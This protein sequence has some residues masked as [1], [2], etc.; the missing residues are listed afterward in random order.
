MSDKSG[1]EEDPGRRGDLIAYKAEDG[2][3]ILVS[4][5]FAN[6]DIVSCS[7][8]LT[9][10]MAGA[11]PREW[12]KEVVANALLATLRSAGYGEGH[13]IHTIRKFSKNQSV[14]CVRFELQASADALIALK[15]VKIAN[16]MCT[17][18]KYGD[19]PIRIQLSRVPLAATV[20]EVVNVVKHLGTVLQITRPLIQG[21]EDHIVSILLMPFQEANFVEEQNKVLRSAIFGGQ[22]HTIQYRCLSE[23][24]VC[25]ACKEKGHFNGQKCPMINRCFSCNQ[26]GHKSYACPSKVRTPHHSRGDVPRQHALPEEQ[27]K[28]TKALTKQPA[29]IIPPLEPTAFS[30]TGGGLP[31]LVPGGGTTWGDFSAI[32]DNERSRS[33]HRSIETTPPEEHESEQVKL[34][35]VKR[36]AELR[37][38]ELGMNL[39]TRKSTAFSACVRSSS[40][41]SF[42]NDNINANNNNDDHVNCSAEQVHSDLGLDADI[43]DV[44]DSAD[45]SAE[46][47]LGTGTDD[48][49]K[50]FFKV[51]EEWEIKD[52]FDNQHN[53][54]CCEC[55]ENGCPNVCLMCPIFPTTWCSKV[56]KCVTAQ[57][58]LAAFSM[59][60]SDIPPCS[61]CGLTGMHTCGN[62]NYKRIPMIEFR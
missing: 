38:K 19:I 13:V 52:I 1:G 41:P 5:S 3:D 55:G 54:L 44:D 27:V 10:E 46:Q 62:D 29:P 56:H 47:S 59:D 51:Y 35:R 17:V 60:V 42:L 26:E 16:E 30:S 45:R 7:V 25:S 49:E 8:L 21:Y 6:P 37:A 36:G 50:G 33:P 18:T 34:D 31:P 2:H 14:I 32:S 9:R 39:K 61:D 20:E 53:F 48:V 40:P 28:L 43:E 57:S 23:I 24:V 58:Q 22:T 4:S 12:R 15:T 11:V